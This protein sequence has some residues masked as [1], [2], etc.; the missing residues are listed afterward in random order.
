MFGIKKYNSFKLPCVR[1]ESSRETK[2]AIV[3]SSGQRFKRSGHKTRFPTKARKI[4]EDEMRRKIYQLPTVK[5]TYSLMK[6]RKHIRISKN[7][8]RKDSALDITPALFMHNSLGF[9]YPEYILSRY[10]KGRGILVALVVFIIYGRT[11]R[12]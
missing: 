9:K 8:Q 10:L 5:K 6:G 1:P 3:K 7:F 4:K 2:I 11:L 12:R